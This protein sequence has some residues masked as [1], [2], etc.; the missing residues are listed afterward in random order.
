MKLKHRGYGSTTLNRFDLLG[1]DETG[2]AKSFAY[3]LSIE[4]SCLYLFLKNLGISVNNLNSNYLD[5]TIEIEKKRDEGRTDIEIRQKGKFHIIVE[6]KVGNNKIGEQRT[7][8]LPSFEDEPKKVLC[9]ITQESDFNRELNAGI[10]V[11]YR[12]WV[13]IINLLDS[14]NFR[15]IEIVQEFIS[16]VTKGFKMRDQKEVL[17]QDLSES[18]E[19]KRY[20]DYCIYRRDITFG[21]PLYFSPYFTKKAKHNYGKDGI[22]TLSKILGVLTI[23]ANN[24]LSFK[25]ELLGYADNDQKIVE[26][27]IKGVQLESV[28]GPDKVVTYYFLDKPLKLDKPLLKDSDDSVGWIAR[29][30][31]K[32]RNVTFEEFT[33]R[34]VQAS[35]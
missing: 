32:N 16:Y 1:G 34:M 7:Q 17:I 10:D 3:L 14:N 11:F 5:T 2:L 28:W 15:Q 35:R 8:Y 29:T 25:D 13:D 23:S 22:W 4:Q 21:S 27:W 19:I 20:C 18:T 33:K 12:G 24:L 9:F 26:Q 31:P 30:I 6:C